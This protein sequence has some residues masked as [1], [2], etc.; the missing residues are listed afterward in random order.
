MSTAGRRGARGGSGGEVE[1]ADEASLEPYGLDASASRAPALLRYRTELVRVRSG[2]FTCFF[3]RTY[4]CVY[5]CVYTILSAERAHGVN[6]F[7]S[8]LA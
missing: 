6:T 4:V 2:T 3:V 7:Y 8:D 1:T 5:A